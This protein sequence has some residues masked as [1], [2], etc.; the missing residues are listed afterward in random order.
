MMYKI[1]SLMLKSAFSE[2]LTGK[3]LARALSIEA[4]GRLAL[5]FSVANK[6]L[7]LFMGSCS[8]RAVEYP[9]MFKQIKKIP[10]GSLILDVGCAESLLS[11]ELT[12]KDFRV[13]G[14]DIRTC[15]FKNKKMFFVKRN[16]MNTALPDNLFDAI[17][18]VSTIEHIG[19]NAYRQLTLED[20]GDFKAM[21]ELCRILKSD[22]LLLF[23]T[24]YIGKNPLRVNSFERNY[25]R[26]RLEELVQNF[27][28]IKEEYFF[29]GKNRKRVYWKKMGPKEMDKQSFTAPG[30]ACLVLKKIRAY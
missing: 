25:N 2:S 7:W 22:G 13:V 12:S 21:T 18:M 29:P 26:H 30:V 17:I 9:W 5:R 16:L 24:P 15:P 27:H 4:L 10:S 23:S 3:A 1:F 11:H 20:Q 14:L 6:R 8:Q 19:L 28:V